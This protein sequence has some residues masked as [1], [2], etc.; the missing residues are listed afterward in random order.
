M[1]NLNAAIEGTEWDGRPLKQVLDLLDLIAEEK[2]TAVRNN[3]GGHANHALFWETM[4]PEGGGEPD[5]A[6]WRRRSTTPSTASPSS[7]GR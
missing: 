7:S 1:T 3:G 6:I 5:G 4:S 2:R